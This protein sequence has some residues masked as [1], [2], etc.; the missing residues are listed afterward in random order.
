[1]TLV[2]LLDDG[3]AI[4]GHLVVFHPE[5]FEVLEHDDEFLRGTLSL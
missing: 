1:M 3:K 5:I 2:V 4:G